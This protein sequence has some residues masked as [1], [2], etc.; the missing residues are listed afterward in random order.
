VKFS[1]TDQPIEPVALLAALQNDAAGAC[2]SFEGWVRNINEGESVDALEYETHAELA[3]SE[4]ET[5]ISEAFERFDVLDAICVHRV[6]RLAIGDCAVWVGVSAGH[7][8]AAFDACRY[9]IDEIKH[10]LPIW[11]KEHYTEGEAA[12]VNCATRAVSASPEPK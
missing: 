4:G 1:I 2:A 11:K 6:G 3:A 10:R 9:I 8:G 7:R 12:W 5:V